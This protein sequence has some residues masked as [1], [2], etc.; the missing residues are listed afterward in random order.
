MAA[1]RLYQ[2]WFHH[3]VANVGDVNG[4]L[5]V[6]TAEALPRHGGLET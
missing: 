1:A 2:V 3:G 6:S 5:K 4:F